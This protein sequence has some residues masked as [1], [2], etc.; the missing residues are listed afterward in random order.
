MAALATIDGAEFSSADE[1]ALAVRFTRMEAGAFEEVVAT[2]QGRVA[3]LASRL[4][5]WDAE[6]D[7]VV[8]DVFLAALTGAK[9]FGGRSSLWT[10]LTTITLNRCRRHVRRRALWRRFW[11][12]TRRTAALEGP[13]ADGRAVGAE[14]AARVREAVG[15]LPPRDREVVVLFYME[16]HSAEEVGRLTGDTSNAVQIRLSRARRKLDEVLAPLVKE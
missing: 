14:T 11:S 15:G 9:G 5:G 1:S 3:R 16:G 12:V 10:W 8:Q 6:V 13:A 7:D 4:L 2:Y